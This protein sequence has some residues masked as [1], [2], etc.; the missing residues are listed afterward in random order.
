MRLV[1]STSSQFVA[2]IEFEQKPDVDLFY[3]VK[4]VGKTGFAVNA[5][6]KP[7]VDVSLRPEV[8]RWL[9][10]MAPQ[11]YRI[12]AGPLRHITITTH[13]LFF[14]EMADAIHFKLRWS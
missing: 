9:E 8:M 11:R 5:S 1:P 13:R 14:L 6:V 7:D 10:E 3:Y 12:S 2:V 4:L